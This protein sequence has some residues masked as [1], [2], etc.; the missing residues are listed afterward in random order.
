M[1]DHTEY[2]LKLEVVNED[3]NKPPRLT[4]F[5]TNG[6]LRSNLP[7]AL[8]Q[9]TDQIKAKFIFSPHD[10]RHGVLLRYSFDVPHLNMDVY[11][12][13]ERIPLN[14]MDI[15]QVQRTFIK[16]NY[17]NGTSQQVREW[18]CNRQGEFHEMAGDGGLQFVNGDPIIP[19]FY[20]HVKHIQEDEILDEYDINK[21]TC[22]VSIRFSTR[23]LM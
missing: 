17:N 1:L 18:L 8:H 6:I 21:W 16:F 19:T 3:L 20:M 4:G 5:A 11:T 13:I 10:P 2:V 22:K 7:S 9:E 23:P 12:V 14:D 15:R